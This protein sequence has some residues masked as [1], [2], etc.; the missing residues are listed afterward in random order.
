MIIRK[1]EYVASAVKAD[2][3]PRDGLPEIA[4][5]GR[6]NVGKSSLINRFLGRRNLARTGNTPGKTQTLNFYR[7]N[8]AW[9]FVDLPG[10]GYAKVSQTVKAQW[11]GMTG[12]YF[13][14]REN[15][16]AVLQIVDIRREPSAEDLAMNAWLR[17]NGIPVLVVA[18]KADKVAR[19]QWPQ[20]LKQISGSLAMEVW[21]IIPFSAASGFGA[22]DLRAAVEEILGPNPVS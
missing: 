3:Y 13:K 7:V 12:N 9:Y 16:R 14:K 10:Y 20:H 8:G 11:G 15:L 19:G 1:A 17:G 6:S 2:Q 5:A 22:D 18:T 4:L 21:Q